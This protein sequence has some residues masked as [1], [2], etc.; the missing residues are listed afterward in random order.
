[1]KKIK[2]MI[3][4]FD[5][6]LISNSFNKLFIGERFFE[7]KKAGLSSNYKNHYRSFDGYNAQ[8][9]NPNEVLKKN[10]LYLKKLDYQS[11]AENMEEDTLT[12]I[13]NNASLTLLHK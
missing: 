4:V 3:N 10:E 1:M 12:A 5:I 2:I 8:T 13:K 11:H 7:D 9:A 6:W